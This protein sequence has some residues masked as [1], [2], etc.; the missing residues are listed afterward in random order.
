[1]KK[2]DVNK[3]YII[4]VAA[5]MLVLPAISI[6]VELS[7]VSNTSVLAMSG[8][9]FVFWGL[10]VRLSVAGIKQTLQPD[11][12][13]AQILGVDDPRS[14]T[15]VRELGFANVCSGLTGM[16]SLFVP[17]WRMAAAFVGGL[18]MAIAGVNHLLHKP[19]G[20]NEVVATVS[21]IFIAAVMAVYLAGP[22]FTT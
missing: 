2:S 3:P 11:F 16:I 14:H 21:D 13:A 20:I 9:W 19:A 12:T 22:L 7:R 10:G 1:M 8:K 15:L 4:F 5:T 17:T 6:A 18:Y